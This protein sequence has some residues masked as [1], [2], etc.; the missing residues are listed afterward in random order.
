MPQHLAPAPAWLRLPAELL[1]APA[2]PAP[3]AAK[4]VLEAHRILVTARSLRSVDSSA[5]RA[6]DATDA[7]G[8]A[9]GPREAADVEQAKCLLL[10]AMAAALPLLEGAGKRATARLARF[11][12]LL[13]G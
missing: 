7:H 13:L 6:S 5:S 1:E 12:A 2:A 11:A 3:A 9:A 10:K 4:K 8:G